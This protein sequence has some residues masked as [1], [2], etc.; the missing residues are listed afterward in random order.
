MRP[1]IVANWKMNPTSR[2]EAE[3]LIVEAERSAG[4]SCEVVICPPFVFLESAMAILE[5]VKVGAQNSSFE[6]TGALTGE[7][8]PKMLKGLGVEYVIVGHSERRIRFGEDDDMINRKARAAIRNGLSVIFCV[9]ETETERGEGKTEDVLKRQLTEGLEGVNGDV[10][11]AYEPVWAIGSGHS[12][13]SETAEKTRLL[14]EKLA[15]RRKII[16]GGSVDS[17]NANEYL[18]TASF[19]GLLIGGASLDA[20]EFGR[21]LEGCRE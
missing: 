20:T 11:V 7:I 9:G 10:T 14:I 13:D 18:R 12:C 6:D 2:E 19:S 15:G 3:R 4:E 5:N 16:Y 21:I 17:S 1:L 8:S